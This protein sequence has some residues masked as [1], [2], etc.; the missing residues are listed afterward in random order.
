MYVLQ[1][2]LRTTSLKTNKQQ[3]RLARAERCSQRISMLFL[4]NFEE[5]NVHPYQMSI[6]LISLSILTFS[7]KFQIIRLC[8]FCKMKQIR[9][10]TSSFL[11]CSWYEQKHP[12]LCH[13]CIRCE[14][15]VELWT[16]FLPQVSKQTDPLKVKEGL[17]VIYLSPQQPDLNSST[18]YCY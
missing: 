1:W 17:Q 8:I 16:F 9:L 13:Y 15:F 3:T 12:V 14:I 10:K 2:S 18:K 11:C 7:T 5:N 4:S 6:A